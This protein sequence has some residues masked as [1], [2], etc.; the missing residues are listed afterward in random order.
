MSTKMQTTNAE[1][2]KD[3]MRASG[4]NLMDDQV[5]TQEHFHEHSDQEQ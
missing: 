4:S 3:E 1:D 5:N 2:K